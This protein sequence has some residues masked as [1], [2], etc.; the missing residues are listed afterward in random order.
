MAQKQHG[1]TLLELVAVVVIVSILVGTAMPRFV[2]VQDKAAL[3]ATRN[4]AGAIE[5]G[6]ALN[7][8]VDLAV[9]AKLTTVATDVFYNISNCTHGVRLLAVGNL[10]AG[11]VIASAAVEDKEAVVCILGGASGS[12]AEFLII[13]AAGGIDRGG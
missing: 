3:V 1:F 6:A 7:H 5:S 2:K 11:Y 10:P 9:E 12:T 13:G 8:A 4:L